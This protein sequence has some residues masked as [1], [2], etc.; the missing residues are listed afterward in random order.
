MPIQFRVINYC[1]KINITNAIKLNSF[2]IN[3]NHKPIKQEFPIMTTL[4]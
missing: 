1:K 4:S 2:Y 3:N